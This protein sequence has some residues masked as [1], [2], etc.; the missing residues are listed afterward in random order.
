MNSEVQD[1][2]E[3]PVENLFLK[4]NGHYDR[5]DNNDHD[6][7]NDHHDDLFQDS[8]KNELSE[9]FLALVH[10]DIFDMLDKED[11]KERLLVGLNCRVDIILRIG[12]DGNAEADEATTF[13]DSVAGILLLQEAWLPPI[14]EILAFI[15][16]IR[17]KAPKIPLV[18]VL[19]GK[20]G[21][22][23]P[24]TVPDFQDKKIWAVKIKGLGD[25]LIH[26]EDLVNP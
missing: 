13:K 10:D 26:V 6:N 19:I 8:E 20:P 7:N 11:F 16:K 15:L 24:L 14:R 9:R 17:D 23:T 22:D 4:P 5:H 25:P 18:V 21:P 3:N 12:L 2:V 1:R